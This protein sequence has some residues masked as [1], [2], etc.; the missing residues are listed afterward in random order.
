MKIRSLIIASL[1]VF[2]AVSTS[3][4]QSFFFGQSQQGRQADEKKVEFDYD[5]DF[6]YYFDNR[7]F[8]FSQ[9]IFA[10][11]KVYNKA[12]IS[13]SFGIRAEQNRNI[14]HLLMVGVDL[15]KNLG[16]NPNGE[17]IYYEEEDAETLRNAK[18]FKDIFYYYNLQARTW[19]GNLDLFAGIFPRN[20]MEGEYSRVFFS[21]VTK[22][23]DPDLEGLFVKFRSPR[24]YAEAGS[25]WLGYRDFDRHERY[26]VFTAGSYS[27]LDWLSAGWAATYIHVGDSYIF[28]CDAHDAIVNPYVKADFGKMT[29]LQELSV[30]AGGLVSMQIDRTLETEPYYPVAAESVITVR[31]WNAGIENTFFFGDNMMPYRSS[32]YTDALDTSY[33]TDLLYLGDPFYFTHRGFASGYDRLE[34]FYEPK[35][36]DGLSLR[37]SAVGHCIFP[38]SEVVGSFLGWQAKASVIFDLDLL[39][40]PRQTASRNSG[41]K[42]RTDSTRRPDSPSIR[43]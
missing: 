9:D 8:K 4:A 26:M 33:F 34:L 23:I 24:L 29:G 36:S 43:L 38:S 30:K 22:V 42:S 28:K 10:S 35:I 19:G 15:T 11:S 32:F 25:D 14:T 31:N 39:R 5:I 21:D 2:T 13:P 7:E 1:A 16:E 20:V 6:Q 37:L 3:S 41:K 18:H 12:R 17:S 27:I 40:H